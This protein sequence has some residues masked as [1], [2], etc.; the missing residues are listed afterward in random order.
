[1]TIYRELFADRNAKNKAYIYASSYSSYAGVINKKDTEQWNK[2]YNKFKDNKLKLNSSVNISSLS[3]FPSYKLKNYIEENNLN[4]AITRKA[5]KINTIILNNSFINQSYFPKP[6]IQND[7]YYCIPYSYIMDN[8]GKYNTSE[9]YDLTNIPTEFFLIKPN[10]LFEFINIDS[11]FNSLS[12]FPII[13]GELISLGHGSKKAG[14][15]LEFF[16]N[17]DKYI[18][19]NNLDIVFDESISSEINKES[20]IDLETFETLFNMLSSKDVNNHIIA[21]ELISNHDFELSKPYILFLATIFKFL[22]NKSSNNKNWGITYKQII[23]YKSLISTY[24]TSHGDSI[25]NIDFF[26]KNFTLEYPQYKQTICNCMVVYLN[27]R[28]GTDLIKEIH[29]L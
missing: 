28:F 23:K 4:I 27:H 19:E 25:N 20:V 6:K 13:E 26:I 14:E 17:L 15:N 9:Y 1:M 7:T 29:S 2:I 22:R 18:E 21:Q 8:F 16:K 24:W 11:K 3:E 10:R 12:E 5:G